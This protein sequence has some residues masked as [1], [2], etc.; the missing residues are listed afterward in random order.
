MA[1]RIPF[2]SYE[3]IERIGEG[4]MAEVWR[5]RSRGVA[6]FEKTV[7]IKRVLPSM[8]ARGDFATLLVREAKIA[9]RLNH[10]NIVQIFELG[11]EGGAYFIAME[12]VHGCDLATAIAFQEDPLAVPGGLDVDLRLWIV[13]E[14]AKALEF[15]HRYRADDGRPL[16]IVHRDISPQNVLLGYEGQVKV[17]DFGIALADERGLGAEDDPKTLRGKYAY[18]SPEQVRGESL[19]RRSDVFSLG[20]VLYEMLAGRRLFRGH[21]S[22]ETLRLVEAAEIPAIDL[23][24]LGLPE[25]LQG[26]LL[27]ALARDREERLGSARELGEEIERLLLERGRPIGGGVLAEAMLR[28]E[29]PEARLR[30]N[31]LRFD[32]PSRQ[33][34][35]AQRSSAKTQS[36]GDE[37]E[38]TAAM[39]TVRI[40][41]EKDE[42]VFV[43]VPEAVS[44]ETLE[45]IFAHSEAVL[46]APADGFHEVI[47]DPGRSE[48]ERAAQ[49]CRRL[50]DAGLDGLSGDRKSVV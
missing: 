39:P 11:E 23:A 4:G 14:V 6:G 17:A 33:R 8:M 2:G 3:L 34:R 9:A 13:A 42:G 19:D 21:S 26:L 37:T 35:D 41:S 48:T 28:I 24:A 47:F 40:R 44:R 45:D 43:L 16:N 46:L 49:A 10:P 1:G 32:L 36:P 27:R 31:K 30:I 29:P 20:I 38:V 50:L 5:A 15:A 7:V 18:M 22:A 25:R 12:H